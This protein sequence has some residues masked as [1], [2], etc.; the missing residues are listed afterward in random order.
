MSDRIQSRLMRSE[1][2]QAIARWDAPDVSTAAA[3]PLGRHPEVLT[4]NRVEQIHEEA[5]KEGF[6]QGRREGYRDGVRELQERAE[7]LGAV[8][9]ALARPLEQLDEELEQQL[10]Q[11]AAILAQQ[12]LRRELRTSPSEIVAVVRECLGLLPVAAREVRVH[13]HPDDARLVR[14]NLSEAA[15]EGAWRIVEDP[16]ITA[17]GCRVV[18]ETSRIDATVESRMAAAVARLLGGEREGDDRSAPE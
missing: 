8:L 9:T 17:G 6:E 2:L 10:A 16:V 13:L 4:A 18:S 7:R 3:T 15:E 14:Q 12:L 1:Q 5:R 11:L